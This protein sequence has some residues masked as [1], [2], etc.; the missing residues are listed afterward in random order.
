[1]AFLLRT[2]QG[3]MIATAAY[4]TVIP[5]LPL[6]APTESSHDEHFFGPHTVIASK[7]TPEAAIIPVALSCARAILGS[8]CITE[9]LPWWSVSLQISAAMQT[10]PAK[11]A[12]MAAAFFSFLPARA[13]K[14]SHVC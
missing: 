11:A 12:R 14:T 1:M 8:L 9:E 3:P 13:T 10:T 6:Y 7:P 2:Y 4:L 5:V